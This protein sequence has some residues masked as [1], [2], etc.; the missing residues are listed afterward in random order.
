ML[1]MC[2]TRAPR[3]AQ[4]LGV[5]NQDTAHAKTKRGRRFLPLTHCVLLCERELAHHRSKPAAGSVAALFSR[6]C[7][8]DSLLPTASR[9]LS[10]IEFLYLVHEIT[11]FVAVAEIH[12]A[13]F[14]N[15]LELLRR[16]L[17]EFVWDGRRGSGRDHLG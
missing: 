14:E 8:L 7:T 11:L 16:E 12:A 3:T 10:L 1:I 9:A 13:C 2:E 4:E 17:I 15:L 6:C 5:P